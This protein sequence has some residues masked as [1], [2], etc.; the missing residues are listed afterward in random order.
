MVKNLRKQDHIPSQH[1]SKKHETYEST[2]SDDANP[3]PE[4]DDADTNIN[5]ESLEEFKNVRDSV[6]TL[7]QTFYVKGKE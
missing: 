4:Q 2:D 7:K 6:E 1:T 5:R 3:E